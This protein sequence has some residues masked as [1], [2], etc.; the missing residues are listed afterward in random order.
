MDSALVHSR[1]P[2]KWPTLAR[3]PRLQISHRWLMRGKLTSRCTSCLCTAHLSVAQALPVQLSVNQASLGKWKQ[4]TCYLTRTTASSILGSI[5]W[6]RGLQVRG[7][8]VLWISYSNLILVLTPADYQIFLYRQ[9]FKYFPLP[10]ADGGLP[11][12]NKK[13]LDIF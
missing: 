10:L 7:I 6:A 5:C 9:V 8:F 3:R 4:V 11:T 1:A 13:V 12:V 2:R